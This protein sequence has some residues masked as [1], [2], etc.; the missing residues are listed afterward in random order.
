MGCRDKLRESRLYSDPARQQ[1]QE[2]RDMA[3]GRI[4]LITKRGVAIC[5][6]LGPYFGS[7]GRQGSGVTG[8]F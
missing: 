1:G 2:N 8:Q 3:L 7:Q 5:P 6:Y 4:L